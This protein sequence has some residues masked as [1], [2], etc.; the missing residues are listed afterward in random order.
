MRR[1]GN[2]TALVAPLK[3]LGRRLRQFAVTEG[4]SRVAVLCV[5]LAAIQLALD[6]LLVLGIGP[7]A[8]LLL[9]IC[10]LVGRELWRRVL[11]PL[12]LRVDPIQVAELVERKRPEYRDRLVSAVAFATAPGVNP[13]R[14]SPALVAEVIRGATAGDARPD[15]DGI[16][17]HD[18]Y[19]TFV[20]IGIA[21]LAFAAL[22]VALA[23]DTVAAYAARNWMLREVAYPSSST[24]VAEGFT[25][26]RLRWPLGDELT[27]LA[28]AVDRV[29]RSLHAEIQYVGG[30]SLT[31]SMDRRGRN[32]FVA[33]VGPLAG[34]L[35]VRFRIGKFGVDEYTR[36][37]DVEAV[38]RP[39]VKK[40]TIEIQ[41]PAYARQPAYVLPQGQVSA[42]LIRGARVR[43]ESEMS[44]PVVEA[45]L[46]HRADDEPA[47]EAEV[48]DGTTVR[49]DFEPER[50]G[51]YYFAVRDATGLEDTRPVT[52]T[53]NLL[54]DAPPKA[55]LS[56]P[57]VGEMVV[58]NATLNLSVGCEDNLGLE[59]VELAYR[60]ESSRNAD[61]DATPPFQTEPLPDVAQG[62]LRY[63]LNRA[64]P[65]LP[66]TLQPGNRL[67]VKVRAKDAQP[68]APATTSAPDAP[69]ANLGES[70]AYTL[71]IVTPE[72]L[73]AELGRREN[74]WRRE[75]EQVV[76]TQE[77]VNRRV[78]DLPALA[79]SDPAQQ[80]AR[81]AQ[82]ARTQRQL[83][84]RIRTVLRQFEQIFGELK[85]NDLATPAVRRRLGEGVIGPLR[86]LLGEDLPA[87][88]DLL[89]RLR[90]G[91]EPGAAAEI[92]ALQ[93]AILRRMYGILAEMLKWEGY[94][95]AVALLRDMLR[96][97]KD[98]TED[99]RKELERRIERM[100]ES[101]DA[102]LETPTPEDGP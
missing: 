83:A 30:D 88:G 75:F 24:I 42:D 65:L 84:G 11:R 98:I 13:H 77:Q 56:M 48:V 64:W 50:R 70:I 36:W 7:R 34:S 31:R 63:D 5:A 85:T 58:S 62:Q 4:V 54:N 41:P 1:D 25:D 87:A 40:A 14:N 100:F 43:I 17:R 71:R 26:G 80:S 46:K 49:A 32:Q 39:F 51:T 3:R 59:S 53:L 27:L 97:Q 33:D 96:L 74:E 18:R 6:R 15:T 86:K 68:A 78:V 37:Y 9:A 79:E 21:A 92:E 91:Y 45:S 93:Q 47:A 57:D 81:Y 10:A 101:N 67:T 99:T 73:L 61:D 35:R 28:T 44:H 23:T 29:P 52:Y 38:P 94:N 66:L 76:K 90:A 89:D 82:E 20:G 55:R 60:I 102:S 8:V 2:T 22:A 72:E 16:L 69:P 19:R 95:E 12:A